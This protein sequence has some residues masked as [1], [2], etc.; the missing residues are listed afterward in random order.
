MTL[1]RYELTVLPGY[2]DIWI[3]KLGIFP[4]F[5]MFAFGCVS[6]HHEEPSRPKPREQVRA[7]KLVDT[8]GDNEED[9]KKGVVSEKPDS[10]YHEKVQERGKM[11]NVV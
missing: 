5:S 11:Y 6:E 7:R 8:E 1:F 10:P 3:V 9:I 4:V 2:Q